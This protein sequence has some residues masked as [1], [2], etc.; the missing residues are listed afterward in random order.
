[1][2][3]EEGL[4]SRLSVVP[5][6][7][8]VCAG[9]RGRFGLLLGWRAIPPCGKGRPVVLRVA[10]LWARDGPVLLCLGAS[11]A[12]VKAVALCVAAV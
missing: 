11:G 8:G 1:M 4:R 6:R 12:R 5:G 3:R 7:V 9:G 10:V 2:G